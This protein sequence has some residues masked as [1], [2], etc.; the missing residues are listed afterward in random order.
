MAALRE[1]VVAL[2]VVT[3]LVDA[4]VDAYTGTVLCGCIASN[5]PAWDASAPVHGSVAPLLQQTA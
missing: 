4:L 5:W 3:K 1:P 2:S